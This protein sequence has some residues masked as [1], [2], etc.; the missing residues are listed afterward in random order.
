MGGRSKLALKDS[1]HLSVSSNLILSTLN[2]PEWQVRDF[3]SIRLYL[4]TVVP[5]HK[6][7]RHPPLRGNILALMNSFF[8]PS[9]MLYEAIQA[10]PVDVRTDLYRHIVLSG[11]SS[12]YPG[13][14]SRLEKEVKQLYLVGV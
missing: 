13:L 1:R 11:G 9:E 7:R 10:A 4:Q 3:L 6:T 2:N 12:M 8:S 5:G 14:P